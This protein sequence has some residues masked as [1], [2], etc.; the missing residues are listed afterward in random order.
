MVIAIILVEVIMVLVLVV[1]LVLL[2]LFCL[3]KTKGV[4]AP[5]MGHIVGPQ[6]VVPVVPYRD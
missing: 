4:A 2:V 5:E 3:W 1:L 6:E